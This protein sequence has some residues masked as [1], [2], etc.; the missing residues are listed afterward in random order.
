MAGISPNSLCRV[1]KLTFGFRLH[2]RFYP[3]LLKSKTLSMTMNQDAMTCKVDF[4]VAVRK[5]EN[6]RSNHAHYS[7]LVTDSEL[8]KPFLPPHLPPH[9]WG[10][11]S[12]AFE[13]L[14][15]TFTWQHRAWQRN[16][17]NTVDVWHNFV[18]YFKLY[19]S[20]FFCVWSPSWYLMEFKVTFCLR[21]ISW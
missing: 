6:V 3:F 17:A 11:S 15:T 2:F 1:I 4:S 16:A 10:F 8:R 9:G 21:V 19:S 18:F 12:S 13:I 20:S 7:T 5:K 14:N